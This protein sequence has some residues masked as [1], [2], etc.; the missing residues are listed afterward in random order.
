MC[1][2]ILVLAP[3]ECARFNDS[4]L[5]CLQW[6]SGIVVCLGWTDSEMLLCVQD[7]GT[8]I[9][10]DMFGNL[11]RHFSMGQVATYLLTH[12]CPTL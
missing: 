5:I 7:D 10:Y 11:S 9:E 4:V 8:V 1:Y 3:S 2:V 12:I 6:S